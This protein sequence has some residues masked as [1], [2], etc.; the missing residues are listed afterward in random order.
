MGSCQNQ[1]GFGFAS[2]G[3][4]NRAQALRFHR[5][6][7]GSL[8]IKPTRADFAQA[9]PDDPARYGSVGVGFPSL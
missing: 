8:V 1:D 6:V 3:F 4:E 7:P 5:A 9:Q 2:V